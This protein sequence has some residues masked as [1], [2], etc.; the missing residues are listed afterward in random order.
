[1][2]RSRTWS[3]RP[4]SLL[5]PSSS[6]SSPSPQVLETCELICSSANVV[7]QLRTTPIMEYLIDLLDAACKHESRS[8]MQ[9][10]L[11]AEQGRVLTRDV[12]QI[13]AVGTRF[14]LAFSRQ[15]EGLK[16]MQLW[17][18]IQRIDPNMQKVRGESDGDGRR[19]QE[20][21]G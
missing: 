10:V 13:L 16:H 5:S 12:L 17:N 18:V 8:Y 7:H 19:K 21:M 4:T 9:Q 6:S 1:M 15:E 3:F 14:L 2:S 20:S 11:L